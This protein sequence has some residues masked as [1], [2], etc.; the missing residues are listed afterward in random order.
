[1]A[2]EF[3]LASEVEDVCDEC[4]EQRAENVPLFIGDCG[5]GKTQGIYSFGRKKGVKVVTFILSNTVP[6]E[7]SGIR[8]PDSETKKMEVFDDIRMSSLEDGDILFLDEILEAPKMIWSA[9]LTLIQDRIMASGKKLPNVMIVAASNPVASPAIIQPSVRDRF[10]VFNTKF[11]WFEWSNWFKNKYGV[12]PDPGLRTRVQGD[13]DTYNILSPR[14]I[15]K[16][17]EWLKDDPNEK[18]I[19]FVTILH[20]AFVAECLLRMVHAVRSPGRQVIDVLEMQGIE[21]PDIVE[22]MPLKDMLALLQEH[23]EWPSIMEALSTV[24][25]DD[26]NE[27]VGEVVKF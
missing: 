18:R 2:D 7:V 19:R 21:C 14:K 20:D 1:M 24:N 23:P 13:S 9:C 25:Y 6:S 8:M 16:L 12:A 4:Y 15:T 26:G 27:A 11:D 10:M 5:I 17:Y 22:S 3:I